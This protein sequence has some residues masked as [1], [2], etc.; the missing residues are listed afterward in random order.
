MSNPPLFIG[1][2]YRSPTTSFD[3]TNTVLKCDMAKILAEGNVLILGDF[4]ARI[5]EE[6][7]VVNSTD[8]EATEDKR[9][10]YS[11]KS[12]DKTKNRE[13]M[14]LLNTMNA[15]NLVI[16]NGVS[17]TAEYTCHQPRGSSVILTSAFLTTRPSSWFGTMSGRRTLVIT[18]WSRWIW[19]F[20]P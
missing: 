17:D 19:T 8:L 9:F 13:G 12:K 3:D 1:G 4:N 5:G 16:L 7:S 18:H 15:L 2:V 11:R 10:V 6:P 14:E 20:P